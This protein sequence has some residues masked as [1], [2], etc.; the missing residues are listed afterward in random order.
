MLSNASTS[1]D[2]SKVAIAAEELVRAVCTNIESIP[3]EIGRE[4]VEGLKKL[5]MDSLLIEKSVVSLKESI[6]TKLNTLD[7]KLN[8][9]NQTLSITNAQLVLLN[10]TVAQ[11][12]KC[13]KL[14]WAISHSDIG[15][16]KYFHHND[17]SR[18]TVSTVFVKEVLMC[19]RKGDGAYI[20]NRSVNDFYYD[21]ET[22]K[23]GEKQFRE[24]LC[25]QIHSLIGHKPRIEEFPDNKYAI[26]YL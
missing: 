6:D 20:S 4:T 5:S 17:Y 10:N 19:F 13:Q 22:A 8:T 26:Y 18:E 15:S 16:F 9:L 2:T 12:F 7:Q 1:K 21:Q 23:K 14:E 11:Q 25:A 3:I 24:K